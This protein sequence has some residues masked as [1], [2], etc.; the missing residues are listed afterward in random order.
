MPPR[1]S[2]DEAAAIA[3]AIQR[4]EAEMAPAGAAQPGPGP[5]QRAALLEGI[6]AKKPFGRLD[7]EGGDRWLS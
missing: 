5:W 2:A 7:G 1:P 6:G 4:F 3:A